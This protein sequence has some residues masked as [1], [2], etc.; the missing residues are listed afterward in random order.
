MGSTGSLAE[1]D[2]LR[3]QFLAVGLFILCAHTL[4]GAAV[5]WKRMLGT[6]PGCPAAR[7]EGAFWRVRCC[8]ARF[9]LTYNI[10]FQELMAL[11]TYGIRQFELN[12]VE[13]ENQVFW[14]C[15]LTRIVAVPFAHCRYSHLA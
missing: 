12:F 15:H 3:R 13:T 4:T 6:A 2:G 7:R 9:L 14:E 8:L 5:R 1:G 11:L 10:E